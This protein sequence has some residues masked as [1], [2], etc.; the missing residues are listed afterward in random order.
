MERYLGLMYSDLSTEHWDIVDR[1][2]ESWIVFVENDM[3]LLWQ[4]F[5]QKFYGGNMI[6]DF[7]VYRQYHA[8]RDRALHLIRMYEYLMTDWSGF[9]G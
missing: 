2:Q 6:W 8:Y 9:D 7:L 3:I 1:S 4:G 5:Y